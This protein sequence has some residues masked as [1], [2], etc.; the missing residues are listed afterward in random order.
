MLSAQI[1]SRSSGIKKLTGMTPSAF[2][3]MG[4]GRTALDRVG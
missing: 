2:K 1:P 4:K 3:E